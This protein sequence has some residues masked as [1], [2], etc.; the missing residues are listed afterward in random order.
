M[1]FLEASHATTSELL[2]EKEQTGFANV[3]IKNLESSIDNKA[4]YETF[5]A[6]GI[7]LSC[8]VAV[9]GNGKSKGHEFVQFDAK[10]A[11]NNAIKRL[12]GML[13]NLDDSITDEKL[14]E[15]F[16]EHGTI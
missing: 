2:A 6:F 10:E 11:A 5:A 15:L 12:N 4:L 8:K 16:S 7:V 13:I 14:K 1:E 9:D 3:Y